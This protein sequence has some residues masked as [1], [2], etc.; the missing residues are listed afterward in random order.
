[1]SQ[2]VPED[3]ACFDGRNIRRDML[4]GDHREM[5]KFRDCNQTGYKRILGHIKR[6]VAA[7]GG[8]GGTRA[9]S[10]SENGV[11]SSTSTLNR[12]LFIE[13]APHGEFH[14]D[15]SRNGEACTQRII[16]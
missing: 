3:S 15:V 14:E 9:D 6:L 4:P 7:A 12:G 13:A 8:T 2:I 16:R 5:C 1:M 10:H 11:S